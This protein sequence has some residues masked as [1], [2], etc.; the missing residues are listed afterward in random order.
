MKRMEKKSLETH[1]CIHRLVHNALLYLLTSIIW[2]APSGD[3]PSISSP[4]L[5]PIRLK[6][7]R[8]E[9]IRGM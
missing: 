2:G 4:S 7:S 6:L 3:S 9:G 8:N 5:R 1:R